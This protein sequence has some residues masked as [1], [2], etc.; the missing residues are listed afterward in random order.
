MCAVRL[1][2]KRGRIQHRA[3]ARALQEHPCYAARLNSSQEI[4]SRNNLTPASKYLFLTEFKLQKII[5]HAIQ[6]EERPSRK[7]LV[8]LIHLKAFST[9]SSADYGSQ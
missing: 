6:T 3:G 9:P 1:E 7:N 8:V 5:K 2:I 4:M